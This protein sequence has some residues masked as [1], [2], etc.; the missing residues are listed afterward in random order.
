MSDDIS[1]QLRILRERARVADER[2]A[3]I[4]EAQARLDDNTQKAQQRIAEARGEITPE[5]AAK[6]FKGSGLA[7]APKVAEWKQQNERSAVQITSLREM[8]QAMR[9]SPLNRRARL[10]RVLRRLLK[11]IR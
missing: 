3:I 2:K 5:R 6:R 9:E 10:R 7:T 11:G 8:A 4:E 1:E